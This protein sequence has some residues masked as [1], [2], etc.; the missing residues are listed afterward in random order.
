MAFRNTFTTPGKFSTVSKNIVLLLIWRVKVFLRAEGFA[1]SLVMLPVSL[2]SKIL[3]CDVKKK[4]VYFHCCTRKKSML[5]RCPC[6][7]PDGPTKSS[8][9]IGTAFTL[10]KRFLKIAK[11]AFGFYL[12]RRG[13]RKYPF[14]RRPHIKN[15]HSMNPSAPYFWSFMTAKSQM[16]FLPEE[17]YITGDWTGKF[18]VSKRQVYTLQ[19]ATSGAKVRVKSFPSIFE[20][21]SPS[22]WNI[23]KEMNTLTKPRMDLIDEQMLTKKQRLDYVRAGLLPK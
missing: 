1:H 16:A 19:H 4:I 12:A 18:F 20:F 3:L 14:L 15:T 23:G 13:Q 7:W 21:N 8:V 5:R 2:Y 22:R 9:S 6:V 17:N 11:S 10:Q